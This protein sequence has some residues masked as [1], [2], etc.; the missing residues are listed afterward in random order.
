MVFGPRPLPPVPEVQ[1]GTIIKMM[2]MRPFEFVPKKPPGLNGGLQ[3]T[4]IPT[5]NAVIRSLVGRLVK[6]ATVSTQCA[7][8]TEVCG[9]GGN[10]GPPTTFDAN[11]GCESC[12]GDYACD[13]ATGSIGNNGN[14]GCKNCASCVGE[15]AC[16]NFGY[17]TAPPYLNLKEGGSIGSSSCLGVVACNGAFGTIGDESCLGEQSCY[18]QTGTIGNDSW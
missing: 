18:F 6:P 2:A 12:S 10:V 17:D 3:G 5:W 1:V 15:K 16:L 7:S 11:V 4:M 8:G 9:D 13:G 14:P